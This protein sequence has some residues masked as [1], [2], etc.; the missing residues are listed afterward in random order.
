LKRGRKKALAVKAV[1][2]TIDMDFVT[3]FSPVTRPCR[4]LCQGM[5]YA[6]HAIEAGTANSKKENLYFRK[7]DSAIANPFDKIAKASLFIQKHPFSYKNRGSCL[8]FRKKPL[9]ISIFK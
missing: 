1:E 6:D 2:G 5:N 3:I 8:R 4:I 9:N 7:D